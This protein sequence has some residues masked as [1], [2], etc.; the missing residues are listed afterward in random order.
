MKF[1]SNVSARSTSHVGFRDSDGHV[2]IIEPQSAAPLA[3]EEAHK[4][5]EILKAFEAGQYASKLNSLVPSVPKFM[6]RLLIKPGLALDAGCG[7]GLVG[8]ELLPFGWKVVGIDVIPEAVEMTKQRFPARLGNLLR[9]PFDDSQFDIGLCSMV[10][11]LVKN[12]RAA[13]LELARVVRNDGAILTSVVN[14]YYKVL[15]RTQALEEKRQDEIDIWGFNVRNRLIE[16]HYYWRNLDYYRK[17]L[18]DIFGPT[19]MLEVHINGEIRQVFS[20]DNLSLF[21]EY[22]WF[23]SKNLSKD[24]RT[25]LI[26]GPP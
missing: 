18:E 11:M 19:D 26:L 5:L 20:T 23:I 8:K 4:W 16:I 24:R 21:S 2:A 9:I 15:Y 14:P 13:C 17:I 6:N 12:L 7:T 10:L 22:I 3:L 1:L 25:N